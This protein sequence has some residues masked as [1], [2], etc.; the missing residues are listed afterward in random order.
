MSV[1]LPEADQDTVTYRDI[2]R[3]QWSLLWNQSKQLGAA[4]VLYGTLEE[5]GD[6]WDAQWVF[7]GRG[8]YSKW[9]QRGLTL[10][11]ALTAAV[12]HVMTAHAR[13]ARYSQKD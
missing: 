13:Q 3:R 1:V 5:A 8:A 4:T 10:E 6:D 7:A 9:R 11:K 12:D 2:E